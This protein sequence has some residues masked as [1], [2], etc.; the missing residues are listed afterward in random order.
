MDVIAVSY[1][2][3]TLEEIRNLTRRE[4]VNWLQIRTKRGG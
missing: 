3:W 1:P 4:R 2:G